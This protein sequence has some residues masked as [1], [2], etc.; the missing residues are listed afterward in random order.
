[1]FWL[2]SRYIHEQQIKAEELENEQELNV[3]KSFIT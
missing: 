2:F 3:I 1:M